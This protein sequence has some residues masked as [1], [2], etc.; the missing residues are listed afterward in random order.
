MQ[1]FTKEDFKTIFEKFSKQ[2]NSTGMFVQNVADMWKCGWTTA[3]VNLERLAW[4]GE[5]KR[6]AHTP[7]RVSYSLD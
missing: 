6:C 2:Y 3:K 5:I 1:E 4:Q 7:T